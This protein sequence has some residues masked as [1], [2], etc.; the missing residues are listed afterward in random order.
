MRVKQG[1]YAIEL[2]R[3]LNFQSVKNEH[4]PLVNRRQFI[5]REGVKVRGGQ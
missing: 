2:G 4:R 3:I 5:A 1:L